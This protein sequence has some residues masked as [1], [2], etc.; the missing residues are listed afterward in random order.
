MSRHVHNVLFLYH[1]ERRAG[2][3]GGYGEIE[4]GASVML[5]NE[6][7]RVSQVPVRLQFRLPRHAQ[8]VG[9]LRTRMQLAREV[10]VA[11]TDLLAL[12]QHIHNTHRR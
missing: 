5:D 11:G 4:D 7:I 12:L 1:V 10:L 2:G 6:R 9:I 3:G 8:T